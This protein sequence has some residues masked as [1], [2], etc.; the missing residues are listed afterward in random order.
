MR[1]WTHVQSVTEVSKQETLE[2]LAKLYLDTA[3]ECKENSCEWLNY[4]DR[5]YALEFMPEL[6]GIIETA[7][8]LRHSY[9]KRYLV[10][11]CGK[12][13]TGL[14]CELEIGLPKTVKKF[15]TLI[16]LNYFNYQLYAEPE[17]KF[18]LEVATNQI[19]LLTCEK[20]VEWNSL[21]MPLCKIDNLLEPC[22]AALIAEEIDLAIANCHFT[23]AEPKPIMR[24]QDGGV[25]ILSQLA[26]TK[27]EGRPIMQKPPLLGYTNNVL[28][29]DIQGE[30]F[31]FDNSIKIKYPT[32]SYTRLDAVQIQ[33][34]IVKGRSNDFWRTF[35]ITDYLEHMALSIEAIL[36]TVSLVLAGYA[37]YRHKC[38]KHEGNPP[39]NPD[40]S[41]N[42]EGAINLRR[43]AWRINYEQNKRLLGGNV[44][45][46]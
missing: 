15:K 11:S 38:R 34:L 37:L 32:I 10:R 8:C 40:G 17:A 3:I 45:P 16:P 23:K 5:I 43:L 2:K 18:G 28:N 30:S 36:A 46:V 27:E 6:Q 42:P 31:V 14:S 20:D 4:I 39:T 29:V 9:S 26:K 24:L 21:T 12:T 7:S 22:H 13:P 33:C 41:T 25:L 1:E 19:K 35:H 44:G